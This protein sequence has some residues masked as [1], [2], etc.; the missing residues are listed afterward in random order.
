M[1]MMYP[2][3][4]YY[5]ALL[6]LCMAALLALWWFMLGSRYRARRRLL[7]RRIAAGAAPSETAPSQAFAEPRVAVACVREQLLC[8]PAM[9]T[10]HQPL[11][12][13][14]W[15]L[16][17]G[18]E[19]AAVPALLAEASRGASVPPRQAAGEAA[20]F[21]RWHSL[22]T[23][24]AIETCAAAVH[25]PA[26]PHERGLWYRALLALV[27][28]RE[29]LPLN[30]IVVCVNAARLLGD[31][32]HVAAD[33]AR[34]RQRIDETAELLRLHL[35]TYLLVTGLERL[36]G[37]K[38]LREA[39]PPAMC[40]EAVGHRLPDSSAAALRIDALLEPLALRLHALRMGLLRGETEPA[41]RRAIH[42]FVEQLRALQPGLRAFAQQLFESPRGSHAGARWRGLYLVAAGDGNP[43]AFISDL[44]QRFLPAD[45]PLAR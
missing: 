27:D 39:L 14:P 16:F 26:T 11:Y 28:H 43:S 5:G 2:L 45:Q 21:W 31:A 9:R 22:P 32:Q 19:D 36:A 42:A 25:E 3:P 30:G 35:P 17:I 12:D 8:S 24:V 40:A 13:L 34:L 6:A 37:Y 41:R 33:A 20:D 1:S 7:R 38:V 15:L 4:T 10:L 29:R 18:D 44:F 23:L